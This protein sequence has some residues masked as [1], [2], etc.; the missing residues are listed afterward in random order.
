MRHPQA[1]WSFDLFSSEK[2]K[3]LIYL[4]MKELDHSFQVPFKMIVKRHYWP[5][6]AAN[7]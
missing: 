3:V 7:A 1:V 4:G 5:F 6:V 2:G